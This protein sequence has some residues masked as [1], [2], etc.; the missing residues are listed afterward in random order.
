MDSHPSLDELAL[1]VNRDSSSS[2]FVIYSTRSMCCEKAREKKK[3][4]RV[5]LDDGKERKTAL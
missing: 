4:K 5:L 1:C 3:G 2:L